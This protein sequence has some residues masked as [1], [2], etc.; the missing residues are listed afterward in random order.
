MTDKLRGRLLVA[1]PS[2]EDANFARAVILMLAHSDE[3]ALGVVLNRPTAADVDEILPRWRD[4]AAPPERVFRGGPVGV[5]SA[6]CLASPRP[7]READ[8]ASADGVDHTVAGLVSVDLERDPSVVASAIDGLRVF[9]G[10]AG[11]GAG[12]LEGELAVGGWI[13]V[14]PLPGELLTRD[15]DTLWERVLRRLGGLRAAYANAPPE[16]SLN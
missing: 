15:P 13:V 16:L 9:S 14:D 11:W 2:L 5:S 8:V 4:L 6:I 12:Q 3:G 10:Y 7:G 1:S